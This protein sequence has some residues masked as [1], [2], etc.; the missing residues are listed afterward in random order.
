MEGLRPLQPSMESSLALI[1]NLVHEAKEEAIEGGAQ[2]VHHLHAMMVKV[3]SDV[4][5][6]RVHQS[7]NILHPQSVFEVV[8]D[9][10]PNSIVRMKD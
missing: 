2:L 5:R 4:R 6:I 3:V 1:D 8:D 10:T 9:G 7:S